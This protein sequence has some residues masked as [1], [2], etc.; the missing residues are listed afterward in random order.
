MYI[1][2]YNSRECCILTE[3]HYIRFYFNSNSFFKVLFFEFLWRYFRALWEGCA[4]CAW[5]LE[6]GYPHRRIDPVCR[7]KAL[8][9]MYR[10]DNK[11][12]KK[13]KNW[14]R[15]PIVTGSGPRKVPLFISLHTRYPRPWGK[16]QA[17]RPVSNDQCRWLSNRLAVPIDLSKRALLLIAAAKNKFTNISAMEKERE[18]N[19]S[20]SRH[21]RH[22][23]C[24]GLD[25][26]L[27][28]HV[29]E[30]SINTVQYIQIIV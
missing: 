14:Q 20:Q 26:F 4:L 11:K 22:R 25:L 10:G 24:L 16:L 8:R 18:R 21:S 28:K 15:T 27:W 5:F 9:T 29:R 6:T 13:R 30:C 17:E 23:F 3:S 12:E 7:K 1:H 2:L 19:K